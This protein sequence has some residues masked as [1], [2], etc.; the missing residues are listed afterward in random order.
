VTSKSKK[1]TY[2]LGRVDQH[3]GKNIRIWGIS[4]RFWSDSNCGLFLNPPIV[5]GTNKLLYLLFLAFYLSYCFE[6]KY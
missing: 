1:N 2:I 5:P 4:V 6:N 3:K